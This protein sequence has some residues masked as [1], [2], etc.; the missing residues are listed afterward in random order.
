MTDFSLLLALLGGTVLL[1]S[2]GAEILR[3]RGYLPSELMIATA[4]GVVLGPAGIDAVRLTDWGA[5]MVLVEE[6]ARLTVAIA[7]TSIALQ[8]PRD[9]VRERARALLVVLGPVMA[10]TWLVSSAVAYLTVPVSVATALLVGAVLTPTDPVIATSI[11]QGKTATENIPVRL[12]YLLTAEAGANDGAAYVFVFFA[13]FVLGHTGDATLGEW[14]TTTVGLELVGA[15]LLGLT[16]GIAVGRAERFLS[17]SGDL[18]ET[19]VFTLA[20][21]LTFTVVGLG[22]VLGIDGVLAVFVAGLGYNLAARAEDESRAQS[23][24][25]VFNR[26]FTLPI[27]VVFG[28]AIPWDAWA[29]LGW[30]GIAFV[31]GVLLLRRLPVVFALR[32]GIEPLDRPE[33]TLFVGWFG[34]IGVTALFYAAIAVRETGSET[35]WTLATLA[36]AGSILAHGVTASPA[37]HWYGRLDD[38]AKWW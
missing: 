20:I 19:S 6:I 9:Y 36:V 5:P 31:A 28:A 34:P 17:A 16:L 8:L 14:A 4:I 30:R 13:L 37:T 35:P 23:V 12:R 33:A 38:D 18:D 2:L 21:A 29:A 24:E 27:F 26:L 25:E 7:V 10:V 3:S 1:L 11:T 32:R 22:S 15:V